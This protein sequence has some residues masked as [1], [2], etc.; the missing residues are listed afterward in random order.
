MVDGHP[1]EEVDTAR[2]D[3]E[4]KSKEIESS[5][6]SPQ[7]RLK[8]RGPESPYSVVMKAAKTAQ[9]VGPKFGIKWGQNKLSFLP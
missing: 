7:A 8:A 5:K 4:K 6:A 3:V 9:E 1:R 2:R